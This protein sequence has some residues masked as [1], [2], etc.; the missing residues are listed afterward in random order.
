MRKGYD[1]DCRNAMMRAPERRRRRGRLRT[2]WR[3]TAE[4]ERE[5]AGCRS[6]SE[7]STASADRAGWRQSVEALFATWCEEVR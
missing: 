2:T 4:K 1:K 7:M 6:W 3:K 5:R